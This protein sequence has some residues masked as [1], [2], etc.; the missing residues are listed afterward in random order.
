MSNTKQKSSGAKP[1]A[2]GFTRLYRT[3]AE[4]GFLD[5]PSKDVQR[6]L[7]LEKNMGVENYVLEDPNG[8]TGTGQDTS[9]VGEA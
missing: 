5:Y 1:V 9:A 2:D 8:Q 6:L 7:T 4:G 3:D